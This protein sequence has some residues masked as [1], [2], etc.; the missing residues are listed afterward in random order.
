MPSSVREGLKII[1]IAIIT[2]VTVQL[3]QAHGLVFEPFGS[4]MSKHILLQLLWLLAA[5]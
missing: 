1:I 5:S 4:H 3:C 2:V